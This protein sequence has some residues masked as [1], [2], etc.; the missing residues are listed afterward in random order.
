M[1][2]LLKRSDRL[3]SGEASTS[4]P[5]FHPFGALTQRRDA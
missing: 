3:W 1:S 2:E 4:Q 5:D